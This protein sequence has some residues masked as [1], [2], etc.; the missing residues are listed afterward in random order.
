[1]FA[2]VTHHASTPDKMFGTPRPLGY[3]T[4]LIKVERAK[5]SCFYAKSAGFPTLNKGGGG[6]GGGEG[7]G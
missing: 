4:P 2:N 3:P 7:G 5:S 1:M 6:G